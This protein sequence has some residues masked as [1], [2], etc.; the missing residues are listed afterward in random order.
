MI[1]LSR[2][3]AL[4]GLLT[5]G[6]T[7]AVLAAD[8]PERPVTWVVPFPAGGGSD[9]FARPIAA[10]VASRLGQ[11][12]PIDN[13]SGAGGT[14][15]TA[16]VARAPA[17]G[18]TLLLGDTGL[19]Y[20]PVIYPK[21]GFD[22]GRDF[23]AISA[24]ARVP[25]VLVVNPAKLDVTTLA[26]FVEAAKARPGTIDVGSTG[27]GTPTHLASGLFEERTGVK[28]NHIPYRGGAPMLQDLLA[29]QIAAA[30]VL[31]GAI[32]GDVR[33]G[34]LRALAVANR[35]REPVLPDVPTMLE[36]GLADFRLTTWFG[37][38]APK[39]TPDAILDRLHGAVQAA[40]DDEAIK[41]LWAEQG[42]RVEPESRADFAL[43]V[44]R[45]IEAWSR[46][47]KAS[48]VQLE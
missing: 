35:R 22:F 13:K 18:Y 37:L 24:I 41:T 43:F 20:A 4:T 3:A 25:Y 29:G 28:L 47:A 17:D 1:K 39:R 38:F 30:F 16:V 9:S 11:P 10:R 14:I 34:K 32:A 46:I 23:A 6:A 27:M 33:V 21:A 5:A 8:W 26:A 31:A 42:A 44:N 45:E 7:G 19:T 2:R 36:A 12:M 40:L 48:N 15:G